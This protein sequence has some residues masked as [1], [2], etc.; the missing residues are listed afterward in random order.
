MILRWGQRSHVDCVSFC[1]EY[2]GVIW[3]MIFKYFPF[4]YCSTS[5]YFLQFRS[6]CEDV[7]MFRISLL[8]FFCFCEI[9]RVSSLCLGSLWSKVEYL[10]WLSYGF[11][12]NQCLLLQWLF[13][14]RGQRVLWLF[15]SFGIVLCILDK[16][17]YWVQDLLGMNL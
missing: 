7:W 9:Y 5:S 15:C 6:I 17:Y 14:S 1:A 12:S 16:K 10:V 4:M 13:P 2:R 3:K 11:L 8:N